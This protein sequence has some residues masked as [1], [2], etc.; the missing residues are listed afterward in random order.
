MTPFN[1]FQIL[2]IGLCHQ[3]THYDPLK[4]GYPGNNQSSQKVIQKKPKVKQSGLINRNQSK[5]NP[6]PQAEATVKE[7]SKK[8]N[9]FVQPIPWRFKKLS[10]SYSKRDRSSDQWKVNSFFHL[11]LFFYSTL[12]IQNSTL[13]ICILNYNA[14]LVLTYTFLSRCWLTFT[15]PSKY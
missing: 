3:P 10:F 14:P 13:I 5:W 11:I 6:V 8:G 15:P 9:P 7:F 4:S 2:F 12:K 1:F